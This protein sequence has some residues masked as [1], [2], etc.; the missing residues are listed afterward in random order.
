MHTSTQCPEVEP[1]PV[2]S[3]KRAIVDLIGQGRCDEAE[4][5]AEAWTVRFPDDVFGWSVLGSLRLT[6]GAGP[7][8]AHDLA[9]AARLAPDVADIHTNLGLARA[10][11][12]DPD[13]ALDCYARALALNPGSVPALTNQ[14]AALEAVGRLEEAVA[15]YDAAL[16]LS[17]Q[18]AKAL[19]NRGNAQKELGRLEEALASYT[20]AVELVPDYAWALVNQG[21]ILADLGRLRQAEASAR[22]ALAAVPD[23]PQALDLLANCLL[24]RQADPLEAMGLIQRSLATVTDAD[25]GAGIEAKRLFV[26]C[27]R[28]LAP[29]RF[30][31]HLSDLLARALAEPWDRPE[32][33]TGLAARVLE[34]DPVVGPCLA[35]AAVAWPEDPG[36]QA[37]FAPHGPSAFGQS[38]LF[39]E[40]LEAGPVCRLPLERFCTL[41]R[42]ALLAAAEADGATPDADELA[43]FAAL[44]RQCHINE[45]AFAQTLA[46]GERAEALA[47]RLDEALACNA[48]IPAL[49]PVAVA[50]YLPVGLR[51]S[52]S[53]LAA[54]DW[55]EPVARLVGRL[56]A[57][58]AG[59]ASVRAAIPVLTPIEDEVS[60]RVRRQ[61]EENP[62]PRWVRAAPVDTPQG[63]DAFLRR[64][65]P[66]SAFTPLGPRERLD[67]LVAGCG[68]GQHSLETA[69]R[70]RGAEVLAVDLSLA[71][72]AFAGRKARE[73]DVANVT[74]AQADILGLGGL[75]RRFDVIESTGVLH[76][77]ADPEAGWR[78]LL[79]LLRPGGCM[80]LGFYSDLARRD[81][82]RARVLLQLKGYNPTPQSMRRC[83]QELLGLDRD[84]PLRRL[85]L[86]DFYS[87][88]GCRDLLF[89]VCEHAMTLPAIRLFLAEH[90]LS[91]LGFDL[92]PAV[93]AAYLD[94]FP[95]DPAATNL[96]NWH[97]FEKNNPDT[98]I[99]MYQFWVQRRA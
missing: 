72:L 70:Y 44:A 38:R 20:R 98:F 63:F 65:F 47:C 75:D 27:A 21:I 92:E 42:R 15:S 57:E 4:T 73:L 83:R 16:S 31:A 14:G 71:S 23:L 3:A 74:F 48:P 13:A 8:A 99:E 7:E 41:A 84:D 36:A 60:L 9:E 34:A 5:R 80:R 2:R 64:R 39:R 51:P 68:S 87:L 32:R 81:L 25:A 45:Y 77:L 82:P 24:R 12:G 29:E 37:L 43:F 22:A 33:L 97:A 35:R 93:L 76:H 88:S 19:Y 62:Y 52:A 6:R 59:E 56:V 17:P 94:R 69:R 95:D 55:P 58:A 10:E 1:D 50:A 11:C 26:E 89:H 18:H 67:V 86:N 79:G 61:Y 30:D 46:E 90:G 78:V 49:W 53:R 91:F 54:R 96:E 28:L 40:L 85:L 66:L